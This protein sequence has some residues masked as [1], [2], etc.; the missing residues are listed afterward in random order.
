MELSLE[1]AFSLK[2]KRQIIKSIIERLKAR[3]N[4]SIAEVDLN[5]TWKNAVIGVSCVSNDAK[6][7]DSMLNNIVNFVENDGRAALFN[8]NTEKIYID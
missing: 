5:D 6:H 1:G 2:D 3:Y 8:Y 7:I 4:A